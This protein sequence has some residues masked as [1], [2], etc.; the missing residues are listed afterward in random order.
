MAQIFVVDNS[1]T[2]QR[3][4]PELVDKLTL[5][6]YI[7]KRV[8]LDGVEIMLTNDCEFQKYKKATDVGKYA[9]RHFEKGK[10]SGCHMEPCLETLFEK[11]R[12]YLSTT[13][14]EGRTVKLLKKKLLNL[15]SGKVCVYF[16]TDGAWAEK[17]KGP[18][19]DKLERMITRLSDNLQERSLDRYVSLQFIR[20]GE[21]PE[22]IEA[23]DRLDKL[24]S[25]ER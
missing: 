21:N 12:K 4:K 23:L 10:E 18:P 15:P 19:G 9:D 7:L 25:T 13:N 6:A 14:S 2:M 5:L 17:Y 22:A 1:M 8:D 20:F 11:I 3:Y 16:M 24:L